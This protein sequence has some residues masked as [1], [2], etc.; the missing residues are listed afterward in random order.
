MGLCAFKLFEIYS[1]EDVNY[2]KRLACASGTE[3]YN[4][5][6]RAWIDKQKID[7]EIKSKKIDLNN[8]P[9]GYG[10]YD[11]HEDVIVAEFLV[12]PKIKITAPGSYKNANAL[13]IYYGAPKSFNTLD[14]ISLTKKCI[15]MPVKSFKIEDHTNSTHIKEGASLNITTRINNHFIIALPAFTSYLQK[16]GTYYPEMFAFG[17]DIVV[18]DIIQVF[19]YKDLISTE[20]FKIENSLSSSQGDQGFIDVCLPFGLKQ[21]N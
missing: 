5:I 1:A 6:A 16:I 15:S 19:T 8:K 7:A 17:S 12:P 21:C 9:K 4:V 18:R 10:V 3:N 11:S 13:L 2:K 20:S 14:T